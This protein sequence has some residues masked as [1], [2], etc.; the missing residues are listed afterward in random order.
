MEYYLAL[1]RKELSSHEKT[2]KTLKYVL[3]SERSQ[4]EKNMITFWK[5]QNYGD[6]KKISSCQ[7]LG[8]REGRLN[9]WS[10]EDFQAMKL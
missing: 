2:L 3:L 6:S 10:T 1:K 8:E 9:R 7:G 4:P 5:M